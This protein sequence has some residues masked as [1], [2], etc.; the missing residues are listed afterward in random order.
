[1][2][3]HSLPFYKNKITNFYKGDLCRV[4]K[5]AVLL[6]GCVMWREENDK[7]AVTRISLTVNPSSFVWPVVLEAKVVQKSQNGSRLNL[8]KKLA[9]DIFSI[10]YKFFFFYKFF[11]FRHTNS[12]VITE[13]RESRIQ[14]FKTYLSRI[15]D[16][17][18]G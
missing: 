5:L 10:F 2:R 7:R 9:V 15:R 1:M 6:H 12:Q 17:N 3:P 13:I 11:S 16:K 14:E 18:F 4:V 8:L